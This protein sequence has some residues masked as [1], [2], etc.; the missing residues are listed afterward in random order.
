MNP[1]SGPETLM[2]VR[3][4]GCTFEMRDGWLGAQRTL[5]AVDDV[6]LQLRRGEV[7]AIVGE[8]GCGKTTLSR[9]ML[10]LRAPTAGE[11][12][13]GGMPLARIDRKAMAR[14]IQPV[15][16]DPYASLN[17]RR[18]VE[19]IIAD[20]LDIH[21]IGSREERALGVAE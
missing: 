1:S 13:L 4:A 21:G 20:P 19:S 7:L 8:S 17:P 3:N 12:R 18:T 15:F 2:E 9:L 10:G 5:V 11:V 16:Q 6:S 14:R